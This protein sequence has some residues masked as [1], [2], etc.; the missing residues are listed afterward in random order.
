M[1][2][3]VLAGLLKREDR[4]LGAETYSPFAHTRTE[5]HQRPFRGKR[6]VDSTELSSFWLP[7]PTF[8]LL[9]EFSY[10]FIRIL[11]SYVF[12]PI[13]YILISLSQLELLSV[14]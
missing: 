3:L 12:I 9:P 14:T 11:I 2:Q 1:T 5:K 8:L 6:E 7:D 4:D 10:I 13:S